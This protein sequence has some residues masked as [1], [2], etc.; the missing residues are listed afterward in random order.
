MPGVQQCTAFREEKYHSLHP[1][2]SYLLD[3]GLHTFPL[4]IFTPL[5]VWLCLHAGTPIHVQKQWFKE[6][7]TYLFAIS[8]SAEASEA[9]IHLV[10][11]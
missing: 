4:C 5:C 2:L 6:T 10:S 1:H 3:A 7:F 8:N 11:G 9:G